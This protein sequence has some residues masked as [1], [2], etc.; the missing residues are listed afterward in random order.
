MLRRPLAVRPT[1]TRRPS[2]NPE[3]DPTDHVYGDVKTRFLLLQRISNLVTVRSDSFTIYV[4]VQG[5]QNAGTKSPNLVAQRRTGVL[6][7][8]SQVKPVHA[9]NPNGGLQPGVANLTAA[10][11]DPRPQRL[12]D[13]RRSCPRSSSAPSRPW[14]GDRAGA[15]ASGA[16]PDAPQVPSLL[17]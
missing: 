7:D 5:W 8:R 12:N 11:D 4:Q 14:L 1:L 15:G 3:T 9:T 16:A 13:P 17:A 10:R 6:V 2:A